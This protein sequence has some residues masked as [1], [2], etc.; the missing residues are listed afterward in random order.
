MRKLL[1]KVWRFFSC[2]WEHPP[3]IIFKFDNLYLDISF[4]K[5]IAWRLNTL[6]WDIHC[7]W[8]FMILRIKD[9]IF[10]VNKYITISKKWFNFSLT[11]TMGFI[12]TRLNSK[13][14]KLFW[15]LFWQYFFSK[16]LIIYAIA[17]KFPP[18]SKIIIFT[19]S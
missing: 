1:D 2:T 4:L 8:I 15:K 11:L 16:I 7:Q 14:N 10:H 19:S 5:L 3:L 12:K 17:M 18:I 6:S 13:D 9:A